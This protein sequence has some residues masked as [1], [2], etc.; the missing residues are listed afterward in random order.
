M[1]AGRVGR[2]HHFGHR[3]KI[4]FQRIDVHVLEADPSG[5]P[6]SEGFDRMQPVRR[7]L[8]LGNKSTSCDV[9][10][11]EF[12]F[13]LSE[14]NGQ[15]VAGPER[16]CQAGINDVFFDIG[17]LSATGTFSAAVL[18]SFQMNFT[19]V[20]GPFQSFMLVFD[21][22]VFP[23][24]FSVQS[25]QLIQTL[26]IMFLDSGLNEVSGNASKTSFA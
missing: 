12:F 26:E 5:H 3:R 16:L 24:N 2:G 1:E 10:D 8:Q 23:T 14:N 20:S 22:L 19:V 17:T 6:L 18:S 4:Y 15:L 21:N 11:L 7:L 9:Q 25:Y 13:S